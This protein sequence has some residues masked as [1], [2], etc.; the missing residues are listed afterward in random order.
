MILLY[1]K[2]HTEKEH[3]KGLWQAVDAKYLWN[4]ERDSPIREDVKLRD[5]KCRHNWYTRVDH[6]SCKVVYCDECG[7][8]K[9]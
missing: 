6:N 9:K 4:M 1:N 2:T 8:E 5:N 7:K 3:L